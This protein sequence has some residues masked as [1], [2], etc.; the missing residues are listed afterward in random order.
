MSE[1]EKIRDAIENMLDGLEAVI[2][3]CRQDLGLPTQQPKGERVD[4]SKIIWVE[5][6]STT[7]PGSKYKKATDAANI[8]SEEYPKLKSLLDR[9]KGKAT[10]ETDQGSMFVWLFPEKDAVGMSPSKWKKK[11]SK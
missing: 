9:N 8:Q 7:H 5:T 4:I 6:D 1:N 10:I 3:K 11:E 2:T